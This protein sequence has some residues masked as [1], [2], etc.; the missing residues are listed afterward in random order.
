MCNYHPVHQNGR[1]NHLLAAHQAF[2]LPTQP[3]ILQTTHQ[4]SYL[5]RKRKRHRVITLSWPAV[6]C[7]NAQ[8][9]EKGR[10]K[11]D[12]T[13]L[14]LQRSQHTT[15]KNTC[16]PMRIDYITNKTGLSYVHSTCERNNVWLKRFEALCSRTARVQAVLRSNA[17]TTNPVHPRSTVQCLVNLQKEKPST[18]QST[19]FFLLHVLCSK[20]HNFRLLRL[21]SPS[22]VPRSAE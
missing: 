10:K 16:I 5:N 20:K 11:K 17:N 21:P 6:L 7:T 22:K 19:N 3:L 14:K 4:R 9:L 18:D 8:K 13:N 12:K 15:T 1:Q 2:Y